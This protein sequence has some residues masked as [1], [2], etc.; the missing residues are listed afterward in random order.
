MAAMRKRGRA[1]ATKLIGKI[2]VYYASERYAR[3]V[4]RINKIK[5]NENSK[6]PAFWNAI[7]ELTHNE[8]QGFASESHAFHFVFLQ[9]PTDRPEMRNRFVILGSLL[10]KRGYPISTFR[11]PGADD[12]QRAFAGLLY[13]D[14]VSYY[15][16]V[17]R[18]IDPTPVD[19]IDEFKAA[20]KRLAGN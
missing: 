17:F 7:P 11:M 20:M 16:A 5:I 1:L 12:L 14:W 13:G 4:A 9:D 18:N 8:M 2:V 19:L 6:S 15:L 3:S 10:R